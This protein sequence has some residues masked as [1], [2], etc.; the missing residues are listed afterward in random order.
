MLMSN[1]V[2]LI[3]LDKFSGKFL[4]V[5]LV[6]IFL[7][8]VFILVHCQINIKYTDYQRIVAHPYFFPIQGIKTKCCIVK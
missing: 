6:A 4:Y 8:S 5:I 1:Y 2:E 7:V 3:I